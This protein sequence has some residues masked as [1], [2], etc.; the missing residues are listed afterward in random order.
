MKVR[1]FARQLKATSDIWSETGKSFRES[2]LSR[3]ERDS[4]RLG[5]VRQMVESILGTA[6]AGMSTYFITS[7][8]FGGPE[9]FKVAWNES[10][11]SKQDF[12]KFALSSWAFASFAGPFGAMIRVASQKDSLW[13]AFYPWMLAT[14]FSEAVQK[15]GKYRAYSNAEAGR[16]LL[17]SLTP[18][19]RIFR[20]GIIAEGADVILPASVV[21]WVFGTEETRADKQAR[22]GYWRWKL[23]NDPENLAGKEPTEEDKEFRDAM[24]RAYRSM[25]HGEHPNVANEYFY[26]ALDVEGRT[27]ANVARSLRARKYLSDYDETATN[28]TYDKIAMRMEKKEDLKKTIGDEAFRELVLHDELLDLAADI[29]NPD[30]G[31]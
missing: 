11:N 3:S 13:R 8:F 5:A 4:L 1:A 17:A 21:A 18:A 22:T 9:G 24:K 16:E 27:K 29:F 23:S 31:F 2:K 6:A 26:E 28:L 15:K 12:A 10:T 7:F 25:Q 30:Y 14:E 19:S 20:D